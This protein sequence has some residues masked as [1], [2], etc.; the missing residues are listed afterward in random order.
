M[1]RT[2][3]TF[4]PL[5]FEHRTLAEGLADAGFDLQARRLF[6]AGWE[7]FLIS[8][9]DAFRATLRSDRATDPPEKRRQLRLRARHPK[10]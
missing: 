1:C 6:S 9:R 8:R 2:S 5:D 10:R 3:L 7:W 4:V